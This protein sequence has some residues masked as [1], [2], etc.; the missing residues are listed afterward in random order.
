[1]ADDSTWAAKHAA[2]IGVPLQAAQ[3]VQA[4]CWLRD[5]TAVER[6]NLSDALEFTLLP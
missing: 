4:Q 3:V 6:S 1:V 5:P 2:A